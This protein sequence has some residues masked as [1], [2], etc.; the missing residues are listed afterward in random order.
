[1][2]TSFRGLLSALIFLTKSLGL[3]GLLC[4]H[5]AAIIATNLAGA[6]ILRGILSSG[7][8]QGSISNSM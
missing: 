5:K 8:G 6:C 1:M 7:S 4:R 2:L 3:G